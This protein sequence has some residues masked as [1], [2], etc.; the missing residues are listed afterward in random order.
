M[1]LKIEGAIEDV[2]W[3]CGG[4]EVGGGGGVAVVWIS[5]PPEEQL[6]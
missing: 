1:G 2:C 3:V 4:G 6:R 5:N